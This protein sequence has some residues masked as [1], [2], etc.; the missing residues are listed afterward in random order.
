MS[1]V[2]NILIMTTDVPR[3]RPS[4]G[5]VLGMLGYV[6]YVIALA[7]LLSATAYHPAPVI[8]M[9]LALPGAAAAG[10]AVI[11]QIRHVN[12][13]DGIERHMQAEALGLAF[14]LTML[15][16]LT[17]GLLETYARLPHLSMWFV[18]GFGMSAWGLASLLLRRRY[19]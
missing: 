16:A 7:V 14:L 1:S 19:L 17:Y 15:G 5:F 3:A 18:W 13:R 6:L 10:Y 11:S 9:L 4:R 8:G 2:L 12:R